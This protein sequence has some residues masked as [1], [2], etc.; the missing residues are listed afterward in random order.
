MYKVYV[1]NKKIND[2]NNNLTVI[3]CKLK[4]TLII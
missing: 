1:Y 4:I 2:F 3:I